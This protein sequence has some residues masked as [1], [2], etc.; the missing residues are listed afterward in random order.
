MQLAVV[1][2]G[3]RHGEAVNMLKTAAMLSSRH[4]R[5]HIF[6]EEQLHTNIRA[7][8]SMSQFRHICMHLYNTAQQWAHLSSVKGD[9]CHFKETFS[10]CISQVCK[11]CAL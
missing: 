7:A 11:V 4:L 3:E 5:F 9:T 6:A 8:V 1:A 10:P 2:C